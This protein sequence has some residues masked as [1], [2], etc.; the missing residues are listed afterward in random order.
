MKIFFTLFKNIR[1]DIKNLSEH[2]EFTVNDKYSKREKER[3]GKH[4][5]HILQDVSRLYSEKD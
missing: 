3:F 4:I 1:Y 5:N 2:H